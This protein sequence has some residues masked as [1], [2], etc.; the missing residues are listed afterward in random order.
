MI[1][2]CTLHHT[3]ALEPVAAQVGVEVVTAQLG[4]SVAAIDVAARHRAAGFRG[5]PVV[6][7]LMHRSGQRRRTTPDSLVPVAEA[8]LFDPPP[9]VDATDAGGRHVDLLTCRLADIADVEVTGDA[10]EGHPPRVAQPVGPDL[11]GPRCSHEGVVRRRLPRGHVDAEDRTEQRR[12]VLT[13]TDRAVVV[14]VAGAAAVA[15][16]D[17]EIPIATK[18][19][20]AA[21][22][23]RLGLVD[24]QQLAAGRDVY[25]VRIPGRDCVFGDDR[26]RRA[27]LDVVD[28]E[29]PRRRILRV[30]GDAEESLLSPAGDERADVEER[31][32]QEPTVLPDPHHAGLV[33]DED[34]R[35]AGRG[36]QVDGD[37]KP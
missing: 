5:G 3:E 30:E 36:I 25:L 31:I 37:G 16:C 14:V 33:G 15:E 24:P 17:V 28:V 10:V 34:T 4:Q 23:V 13:V 21:V 22:V 20:G 2:C 7:V 1:G 8:A 9:E 35:V 6:A 11:V 19:D 12:G 18:G 27:R 29:E 32:R 26:V